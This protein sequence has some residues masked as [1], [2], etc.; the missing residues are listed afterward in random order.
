MVQGSIESHALGEM[1]LKWLLAAIELSC[2]LLV[3]AS[4]DRK[5]FEKFNAHRLSRREA[6]LRRDFS[7]TTR[8]TSGFRYLTN[9]TLRER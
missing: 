2:M 5:F 3:E 9:T 7:H 6:T 4:E 8:D 1:F